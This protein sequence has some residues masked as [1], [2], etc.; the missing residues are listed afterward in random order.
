[1]DIRSS[2]ARAAALLLSLMTAL[3]TGVA[4]ATIASTTSASTSIDIGSAVTLALELAA[5]LYGDGKRPDP[6][7]FVNR[8]GVIRDDQELA[9]SDYI[10]KRSEAIRSADEAGN[11]YLPETK[12]LRYANC[13]QFLGTVIINTIDPMYPG[14]LTKDQYPYVQNPNNGW[15]KVGTSED[16]APDDYQP[17]DVF[18]TRG[19]GHTFMWIGEHDGFDDVIVEAAY[20]PEDSPQ[21]RLPSL[22]RYVVDKDTGVDGAGRAYDVWRFVGRSGDAEPP[23]ADDSWDYRNIFSDF[24]VTAVN[25]PDSEDAPY[26]LEPDTSSIIASITM[27]TPNDAEPGEEFTIET[28]DPFLFL[29]FETFPIRAK[30]GTE[31]ATAEYVS[32]NA[33][34]IVLSDAVETRANIT[35][36]VRL[37]TEVSAGDGDAR[38][39]QNLNFFGGEQELGPGTMYNISKW[40]P[41]DT[42]LIGSAQQY[43]GRPGLLTSTVYRFDDDREFDSEHV[44]MSIRADTAGIALACDTDI[45]LRY[46][47]LSSDKPAPIKSSKAVADECSDRDNSIEV[48]LPEGISP[49]KGATGVRLG[50][51]W[52]ADEAAQS[53]RFTATLHAPGID[54]DDKRTWTRTFRS[55]ALEGTADGAL[56]ELRVLH[57]PQSRDFSIV[58]G[59]AQ[60]IRI[61]VWALAGVLLAAGLF[62]VGY[63][64]GRRRMAVVDVIETDA[65]EPASAP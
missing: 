3:L 15:E 4:P 13:S 48:S 11:P 30:D 55:A 17:G 37:T 23:P 22:R 1:M 29:T 7:S 44:S 43:D 46:E 60:V 21:L 27:R 20:A 45:H 64:Y 41:P 19:A 26:L 9:S 63:R 31:I 54:G 34:K 57:E 42:S 49:P 35:G 47:W 50:A 53:Y 8:D 62:W 14:S 6:A 18:L 59:S 52:I 58:Y 38:D 24:E 65:E 2:R 5:P 36:T 61:I 25:Q 32:K 16:Y 12:R 56:R 39:R 10:A 51:A 33:V 28:A 40:S